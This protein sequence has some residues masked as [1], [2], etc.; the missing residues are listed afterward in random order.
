LELSSFG[1]PVVYK[2][3]LPKDLSIVQDMFHISQ[4][5]KCLRVPEHVIEILGVNLEL[6]LTHWECSIKV[7]DQKGRVTRRK[8]IKFCK[9]QWNQPTEDETT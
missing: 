3:Q 5:K 8:F 6:D 7:L 4:L 1:G 2:V 9:L